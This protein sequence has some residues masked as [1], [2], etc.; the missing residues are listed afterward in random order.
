MA[1]A[2]ENPVA[3]MEKTITHG[4]MLRFMETKT[5]YNKLN[6]ST[7]DVDVISKHLD[8]AREAA[9]IKANKTIDANNVKLTV[10]KKYQPQIRNMFGKYNEL[11][12]GR[13]GNV[14]ITQH[15]NWT[16]PGGASFQVSSL[17]KRSENS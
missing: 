4:E 11:W 15:Q 13:L 14:N 17:P 10:D 16:Y 2:A 9:G 6:K 5:V 3:M 7:R 8:D 12:S 1:K